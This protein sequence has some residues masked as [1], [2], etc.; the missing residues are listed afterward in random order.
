MSRLKRLRKQKSKAI[1]LRCSLLPV[2]RKQNLRQNAAKPKSKKES[3]PSQA[4]RVELS[5]IDNIN[6][7][8]GEL[9]I[10]QTILSQ[11]RF[12]HIDDDLANKS[13]TELDKLCGSL[14]KLS[15]ALRMV[16]LKSTFQKM[17]RIVRDTS[18]L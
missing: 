17:N 9:V 18:R 8:I 14:H 13:I 11:R 4:I 2:K 1:R 3:D 6:N 10:A 12:S 7:L 16:P 15:M 5:K